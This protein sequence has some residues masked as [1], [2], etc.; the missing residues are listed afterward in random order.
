MVSRVGQN[1][2]GTHPTLPPMPSSHCVTEARATAHD[3]HAQGT[4][5]RGC[6]GLL[7][8]NSHRRVPACHRFQAVQMGRG[9]VRHLNQC[10]S[11]DTQAGQNL[12]LAWHTSLGK[13]RQ[14]TPVP[15][16]RTSVSSA[17]IWAFVVSR[18]HPS[19][20]SQCGGRAVHEDTE[21]ALSNK[22]TDA[23]KF[24]AGSVQIPPGL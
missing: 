1:S 13:Q 15:M 6:Y 7:G 17:S 19:T 3:T 4:M 24:Q 11:G 9:R 10:Q 8:P 21:D 18:R 12:R 20:A 22:Q 5:E 16:G 23:I 14:Q 2:G